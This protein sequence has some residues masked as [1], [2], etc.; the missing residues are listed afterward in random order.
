VI[1][2]QKPLLWKDGEGEEKEKEKEKEEMEEVKGGGEF[3]GGAG[4]EQ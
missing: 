1:H 2:I 4:M 3:E